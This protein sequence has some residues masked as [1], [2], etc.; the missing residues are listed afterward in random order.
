MRGSTARMELGAI[1][2]ILV[3][4]S[5]GHLGEALLRSL[6]ARG[7]RA[8]GLD[9]KSGPFTQEVGSIADPACVTRC[10]R[11]IRTVLH[12]AT[13]HK[14]HVATHSHHD[15][16]STNIPGTLDLLEAAVKAGVDAFVFTSTTSAFGSALTPARGGPAR[17]LDESVV[18]TPKN[19]YGVTKTAAEDL[20][21]L[22]HRLY[23]LPCIV[24]RTSRFFPEAD[25]DPVVRD[26]YDDANVREK[27]EDLGVH[28]RVRSEPRAT[29]RRC[30]R[31]LPIQ[32]SDSTRRLCG[33]RSR[34]VTVRRAKGGT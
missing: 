21:E 7:D 5:S 10:M 29:V 30:L 20:C 25:D 13:L 23:T 16:V 32:S 22:F 14:P 3:T 33:R 19:I 24:L 4:G 31:M 2:S 28:W 6:L 11:G 26:T 34:A 12:T 15:F 18:R 9:L 27:R 8:I 17:W 1:M